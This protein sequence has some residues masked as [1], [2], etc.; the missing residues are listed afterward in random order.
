M[1]SYKASLPP[2]MAQ[3][4]AQK[5][6][7]ST[8]SFDAEI[9]GVVNDNT[10]RHDAFTDKFNRNR[11]ATSTYTDGSI[12]FGL[13]SPINDQRLAQKYK[14][15]NEIAAATTET[16]KDVENIIEDPETGKTI[17]NA[18]YNNVW[19]SQHV[20]MLFSMG[21]IFDKDDQSFFKTVN[22]Y[23]DTDS[24]VY[25]SC[26]HDVMNYK[27]DLVKKIERQ[28]GIDNGNYHLLL[29]L[30]VY[31]KEKAL[32]NPPENLFASAGIVKWAIDA[33]E[34]KEIMMTFLSKYGF[35]T[36]T[37]IP[38]KIP[39]RIS[40]RRDNNTL[41]DQKFKLHS[42]IDWNSEPNRMLFSDL[43]YRNH[44]DE[45]FA[46]RQRIC[47]D[48]RISGKRERPSKNRTSSTLYNQ[49]YAA[50]QRADTVP[51][52]AKQVVIS[53][54]VE[55]AIP[56]DYIGAEPYNRDEDDK[57][58]MRVR[59][60]QI[61]EDRTKNPSKVPVKPNPLA[62]DY[63]MLYDYGVDAKLD[64]KSTGVKRP[65]GRVIQGF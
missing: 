53:K 1:T 44:R 2:N 3:L 46:Q 16:L 32:E 25:L 9:N 10:D 13:D 15:L 52:Y 65:P 64:I 7:E 22:T 42:E 45:D 60:Y 5:L 39:A 49:I 20:Y 37:E 36:Q 18:N 17:I 6:K 14:R 59:N 11:E 41:M 12:M 63:S 43:D 40:G 56:S 62:G 26:H 33:D 24:G 27:D 51:Q 54:M 8:Q 38:H 61:Y 23:F 48:P 35:T 28:I 19:F 4:N 34:I 31:G 58:N 50:S 30:V 57:G 29:V 21:R 55:S 47:E